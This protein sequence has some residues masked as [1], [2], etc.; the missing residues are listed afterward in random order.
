MM[1]FISNRLTVRCFYPLSGINRLSMDRNSRPG[2]SGFGS[3]NMFKTI[4]GYLIKICNN[5]NSI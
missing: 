2:T 4:E 1:C 3:V 5:L